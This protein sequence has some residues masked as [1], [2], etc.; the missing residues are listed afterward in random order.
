MSRAIISRPRLKGTLT[1]GGQTPR[2]LQVTHLGIS[3]PQSMT[4]GQPNFVTPVLHFL[5]ILNI[6]ERARNHRPYAR[7]A[8]RLLENVSLSI[9]VN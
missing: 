4:V 3:M 2:E 9:I 7:K 6:R 1:I 5:Q 8:A